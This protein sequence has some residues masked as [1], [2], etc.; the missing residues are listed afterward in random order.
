MERQRKICRCYVAV[1]HTCG[2]TRHLRP[3]CPLRNPRQNRPSRNTA[4]K[5]ETWYGEGK[6]RLLVGARRP[7]GEELGFV[8]DLGG[9]YEQGLSP[10]D[11]VDVTTNSEYKSG[12]LVASATFRGFEKLWS[13]LIYPGAPGNYV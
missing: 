6:R 3:N 11:L 1:P 9:R 13:I 5:P 10:N 8:E 4:L 7:T 2:N 12:L